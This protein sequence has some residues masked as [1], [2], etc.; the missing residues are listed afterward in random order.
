MSLKPF[1]LRLPAE[2]MKKVKNAAE[3]E[4]RSINNMIVHI[5]RNW[6]TQQE[7]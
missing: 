6:L 7:N 4:G 1:S 3:R 2:L 5:I